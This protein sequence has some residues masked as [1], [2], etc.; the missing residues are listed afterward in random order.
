MQQKVGKDMGIL[1]VV[2]VNNG[3]VYEKHETYVI[4]RLT[5]EYP[6]PTETDLQKFESFQ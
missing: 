4:P 1:Y 5:E 3:L 6:G 2:L